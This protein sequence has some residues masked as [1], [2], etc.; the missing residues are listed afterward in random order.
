[1][2][3]ATLCLGILALG[4]ASGYEIKKRFD[5]PLRRI[6]EP[7]FGSIYPALTRLTR[8]GLVSCTMQAQTKRPNKK[9]YSISAEGRAAL[10]A[11]L[12]GELPGPDRIHSDF[13]VTMLFADMLSPTFIASAIEER[14][15]FYRDLLSHLDDCPEGASSER[16]TCKDF[17]SGYGVAICRAAIAYLEAHRDRLQASLAAAAEAAQFTDA[18]DP[19]SDSRP[20]NQEAQP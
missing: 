1:M 19:N 9:V 16:E 3:I 8:E 10:K 11:R 4:D 12:Q 15:A 18:I 2:N 7:S 20:T 14:I 5:G 6:H 17:V 13:L